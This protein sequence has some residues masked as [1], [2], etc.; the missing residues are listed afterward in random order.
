MRK[1]WRWTDKI[2]KRS[3]FET[4]LDKVVSDLFGERP[5]RRRGSGVSRST[6][7]RRPNF[8]LEILEP[9]LLLSAD[10][11]TS[12]VNGQLSATFADTDDTVVI[13]QA[14]GVQSSNGGFIVTLTYGGAQHTF[15]D[16]TNGITGLSLDLA[17]GND[18]VQLS[19]DPI[20]ISISIIGGSGDDGLIGPN[21][22]SDWL[23]GNTPGSGT[24]SGA[25]GPAVSF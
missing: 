4:I 23:L 3:L 15:G 9:R 16:A 12:I 11:V 1:A 19:Q 20:S 24:V 6:N 13:D 17:G 22:V 10:P 2:P 21:A 8:A 18:A 7:P 14:G 25:S 5:S